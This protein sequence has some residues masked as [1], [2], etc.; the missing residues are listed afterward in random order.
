[1]KLKESEKKG[2]SRKNNLRNLKIQMI[3]EYR[4]VFKANRKDI[5]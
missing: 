5:Q 1:M 2:R 4:K 3:F